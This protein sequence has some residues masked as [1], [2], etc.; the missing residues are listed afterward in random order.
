M[1]R[2][3][4]TTSGEG[5]LRL[6]GTT[7]RVG[8]SVALPVVVGALAAVVL[9]AFYVLLVGSL[10]G[11]GHARELLWQDR[12]FVTPIALGFGAQ[13]GLFVQL[14]RVRHAHAMASSTAVA[15]SGT[16]ASAV[17]MVAC[18]LHHATDVLPV[19]GISGAA[20][21]LAQYHTPFMALALA[22]NLAGVAWMLHL[23]RRA[24]RQ[25][26]HTTTGDAPVRAAICHREQG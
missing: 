7:V 11:F 21:F 14:W 25:W 2:D 1:G 20:A 15:S 6:E 19:L 26:T 8:A 5:R 22:M 13:W 18:C 10:Q 3:I 12:F 16:G 4:V 9:L 24:G 23:L 17:S